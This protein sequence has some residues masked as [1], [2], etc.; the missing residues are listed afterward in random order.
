MKTNLIFIKTTKIVI[1]IPH[2]LFYN[3]SRE[4]VQSTWTIMS[5]LI[6]APISNPLLPSSSDSSFHSSQSCIRLTIFLPIH[7]PPIALPPLISHFHFFH[8]TFYPV[9]HHSIF[10]PVPHS[11]IP[12]AS[13]TLSTS[14]LPFYSEPI[15]PIS[16]MSCFVDGSASSEIFRICSE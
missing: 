14:P 13:A 2:I 7:R 11:L 15:V 4:L 8:Y 10:P 16:V 6:S 1:K 9:I 5:L 3:I 12:F